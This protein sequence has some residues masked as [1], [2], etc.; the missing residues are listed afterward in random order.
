MAAGGAQPKLV[1]TGARGH[2]RSV[3]FDVLRRDISA[4]RDPYLLLFGTSWGLDREIMEECDAILEPIDGLD[5]YNHLPVR[6]AAAIILDRLL[7]P[8]RLTAA[9]K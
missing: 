6:E 5:G 2:A 4:G 3:S 9:A 1:A 7:G 8:E